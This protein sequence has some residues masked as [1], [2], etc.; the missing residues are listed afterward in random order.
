MRIEP[1][2]WIVTAMLGF[3]LREPALIVTWVGVVLVSILVH[4]FGHAFA[5]KAFRQTS[6]III[7]GFGGLTLSQRRLSRAQSILVSLA[8]PLGALCLL[9][10]PAVWLD[11]RIGD[12]LWFEWARGGGGFGWYPVLEFAVYVNIWWSLANLLPIRPLDGGNVMTEIIGIDAA[13]IA[14]VVVAA[15]AAVYAYTQFSGL[16]YA[17]FFAA[18]LAFI[19]FSE[20][21]RSKR[22][23]RGPSAFDVDAPAPK[24][25]G[26]VLPGH[27]SGPAPATPAPRSGGRPSG[28]PRRGDP[29]PVVQLD[30][31]VEPRAAEAF[32]WTLL[33]NGD[34]AGAA[35]ILQ[36]ANGP[37]GPFVAATVALARGGGVGALRAAYFAN[38]SGPSNLMPATVA[39]RTGTVRDLAVELLAAGGDGVDAVAT[40][41]THLHYGEHF[42]DAAAVG[43][44]RYEIAGRARAQVAFDVACSHARAGDLDAAVEWIDRAVTDGFAAPGLL[45]GEDDLAPVRADDR[46]P[47]IRS[48]VV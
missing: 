13:R 16:R 19:N 36:R 11:G 32:A 3:N 41:Q 10:L 30:G 44:L 29:A 39:A 40:I 45:D 47:A 14:S 22:G 12:D 2:F 4:E 9:G 24:G 33:R 34:D 28:P 17:A 5:L 35:R 48:R 8:G 37:V 43:A 25:G 38:P 23:D 42:T 46:W 26:G 6:S 7:H 18:F 31:G 21:R 20:Y 15:A 1:I 27:N